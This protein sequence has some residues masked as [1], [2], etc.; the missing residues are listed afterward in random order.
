MAAQIWC[1]LNRRIRLIEGRMNNTLLYFPLQVKA[2]D[3]WLCY[4]CC[5]EHSRVGLLAKREDWV[6]KLKELFMSDHEMEYVSEHYKR[7]CIVARLDEPY[8]I[9]TLGASWLYISYTKGL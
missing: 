6:H 4:M 8:D 5:P 2:A 7:V 1:L 3:K 9:S